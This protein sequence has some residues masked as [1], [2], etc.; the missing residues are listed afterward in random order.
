MRP[1]ILTGTTQPISS[2]AELRQEEY[3]AF[4]YADGAPV[5]AIDS[6][7]WFEGLFL[8]SS[9]EELKKNA[10]AFSHAGWDFDGVGQVSREEVENWLFAGKVVFIDPTLRPDWVITSVE[11]GGPHEI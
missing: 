1:G 8:F 11:F 3:W 4:C 6:P 2:P 10:A 5:Y 7:S 9:H